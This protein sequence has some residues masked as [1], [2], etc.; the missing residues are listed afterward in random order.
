M[1]L[2]PSDFAGFNALTGLDFLK[3][4]PRQTRKKGEGY[5]RNGAVRSLSCNEP[6]R[7]YE[8]T[9]QGSDLYS[10][11][12]DFEDEGWG[13]ECT[14]PM[15]Y[16][17]KHA[18]AA[19]KQL[20]AEHACATGIPQPQNPSTPPPAQ[21]V[22][23]WALTVQEK[24]GRA[25][26]GDEVRYLNNISKLYQKAANGNLMFYHELTGLGLPQN[27]NYWNRLE[28]YPQLPATEA[29]FWNY[30]A[31]YLTETAHQP[32]PAFLEPVTDLEAARAGH[33]PAPPDTRDRQLEQHAGQP[34]RGHQFRGG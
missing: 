26:A 10:V 34:R 3:S 19:M 2:T 15:L 11:A 27:Y 9:V 13:A 16:D 30:L 18:Y 29:E 21:K 4:F 12:F 7:S 31:L 33:A 1:P 20:L 32:P 14:C 28:L 6:G 23:G 22:S 8:A 5:F 25:L 17:C 24:L